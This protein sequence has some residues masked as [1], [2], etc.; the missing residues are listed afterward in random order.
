MSRL[1]RRTLRNLEAF[2]IRGQAVDGARRMPVVA[3]SVPSPV[4][5]C[6]LTR[7]AAEIAGT[8]DVAP[9]LAH[10]AQSRRLLDPRRPEDLWTISR[11]LGRDW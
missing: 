6:A 8:A 10:F 1:V 5:P 11:S 2:S 3:A 9:D 7:E 4:R